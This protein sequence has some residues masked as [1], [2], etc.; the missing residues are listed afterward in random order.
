MDLLTFT[1]AH[2]LDHHLTLDAYTA[3]GIGIRTSVVRTYENDA[4]GGEGLLMVT[5]DLGLIAVYVGGGRAWFDRPV[6]GTRTSNNTY[7]MVTGVTVL[8]DWYAEW[9]HLSTGKFV[10]GEQQGHHNPGLDAV[11]IGRSIRF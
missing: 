6:A 7:S 1:L 2:A 8:R 4:L 10:T 3:S 5:R 11:F 9:R